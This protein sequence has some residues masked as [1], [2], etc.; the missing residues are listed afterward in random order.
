MQV[1]QD[2]PVLETERLILR[3]LNENDI[4]DL[5]EIF[6]SEEVMKYYGMFP[7]KNKDELLKIIESFSKGFEEERVIRWGIQT[8]ADGKIIGTCGFHNW[9]Q[10]HFRAEIGYELSK[11][12]WHKGY[13]SE[14]IKTIL[15]YGFAHMNL[16]RIEG[17]VY[18]ENLASQNTLIRLGFREEGLLREYMCFR[19]QMTNVLMFSLLK[20]EA[21]HLL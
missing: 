6:S 14:A 9:S 17:I 8:K 21:S 12:F 7:F 1:N 2:F 3:E 11:A 4:E 16:N 5:Y 15:Q 20:K 19:D 10:K 13:M 18:P